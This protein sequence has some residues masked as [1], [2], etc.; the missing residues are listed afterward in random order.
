MEP[1]TSRFQKTIAA[2]VT[3]K[4]VLNLCCH[5]GK[6]GESRKNNHMV[7]STV[8]PQGPSPSLL[9]AD[10]KEIKSKEQWEL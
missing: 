10:A 4:S 7:G 1:I 9:K 5:S 6:S 8:I 2:G 3:I